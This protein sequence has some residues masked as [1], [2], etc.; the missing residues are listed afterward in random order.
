MASTQLAQQIREQAD[1]VADRQ[2]LE[3]WSSMSSGLQNAPS[4]GTGGMNDWEIDADDVQICLD[5]KNRPWQLG[6]G[7]FGRVSS[8]I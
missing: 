4:L 1:P 3:L 7:G 2:S 6:S 5:S 8:P